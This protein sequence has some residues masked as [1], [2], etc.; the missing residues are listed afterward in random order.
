M[1]DMVLDV[2]RGLGSDGSREACG[3]I[4]ANRGRGTGGQKHRR[5]VRQRPGLLSELECTRDEVLLLA[6]GPL[7]VHDDGVADR[8]GHVDAELRAS[9]LDVSKELRAE[10][11]DIDTER[12]ENTGGGVRR[13]DLR[14]HTKRVTLEHRR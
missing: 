13:G 2:E 6:A 14:L 5:G 9:A 10:I 8:P 1:M 7:R 4:V 3:D 12:A 11:Q